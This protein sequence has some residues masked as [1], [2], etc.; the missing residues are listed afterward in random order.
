VAATAI[1]VRRAIS[2]YGTPLLREMILNCMA[3]DFSWKEPAKKWEEL[4]LSL[5]VQ[6]SEQGFEGEEPIP[7]TKE[8]V[9]T[10]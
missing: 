1:A 8:N 2:A 10:P 5:E 9:A 7:L 4:L 3:Q 6:G